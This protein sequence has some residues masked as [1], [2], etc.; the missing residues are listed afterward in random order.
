MT[1]DIEVHVQQLEA[2]TIVRPIGEID[3]SRAPSFRT[4]LVAANSKRPRKLIVDLASVGYMDSSGI[5]T[6]V[7]TMRNVRQNGGKLILC[8]MQNKVR[9]VFEIARLHTVFTIVANVDEGLAV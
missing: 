1:D 9:S 8:A 4:H 2:A 6:L 7:E 3:L 5:A